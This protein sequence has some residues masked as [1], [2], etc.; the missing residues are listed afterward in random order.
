VTPWHDQLMNGSLETPDYLE[1]P[2]S[3][4]TVAVRVALGLLFVVGGIF[5]WRG[6]H[7]ILGAAATIFFGAMTVF[8]C[9]F[10]ADNSAGLVLGPE[11]LVINGKIG[12][13]GKVPWANVSRLSLTRYGHDWMMLIEVRDP[14]SHLR[15]GSKPYRFL[16]SLSN[17]V[18]D[19]P[20]RVNMNLLACDRDELLRRAR[21]MWVKYGKPPEAR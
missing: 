21:E 18:F 6:G 2:L 10:F 11:G 19:T 7:L 14:Q 16:S 9:R 20:V 17:S 12:M 13:G 4:G 3:Y 5:M 15:S 8:G 1:I